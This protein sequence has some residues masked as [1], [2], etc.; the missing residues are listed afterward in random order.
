VG[1]R[2]S[3]LREEG[4]EMGDICVELIANI[5]DPDLSQRETQRLLLM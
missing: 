3:S 4:K 1:G 5:K 2:C